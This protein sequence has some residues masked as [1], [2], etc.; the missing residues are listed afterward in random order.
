MK[1]IIYLLLLPLF[2][3]AQPAYKGTVIAAKD[4][5]PIPFASV[6][7]IKENIGINADENGYFELNT[8]HPQPND[9]LVISSVGFVTQK[10][11]LHKLPDSGIQITLPEEA[12]TLSPVYISTQKNWTKETLNDY[13][14]CGNSFYTSSGFL[15]QLA[16]HFS[17]PAEGAI[18]THIRICRLTGPIFKPAKAR[19][20]IRVYGLDS[21]TG[22]PG[23]DLCDKVIE[24]KSKNQSINLN[25]EEYKIR[26]PGHRFF[27]AIE[28]IRIPYN[29]NKYST[30]GSTTPWITYEPQI[31]WITKN[32]NQDILWELDYR[33]SWYKVSKIFK[34]KTTLISATVKY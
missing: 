2:T 6:G 28:W 8:T 12:I 9:S 26:I 11:S 33:N 23:A 24:V 14:D 16:Q 19:F 10:L 30:K 17:S 4:H 32:D 15:K 7:L 29:E 31:G 20:R 21:I 25:L 18:L 34:D 22:G 1:T 27:I 3:S 13:R 5:Q